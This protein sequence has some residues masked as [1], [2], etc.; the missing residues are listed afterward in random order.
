MPQL[1]T[2]PFSNGH[3]ALA[4]EQAGYDPS[5]AHQPGCYALSCH[6]PTSDLERLTRRWLR[7]SDH[8]PPYLEQCAQASQ[9]VYV[10]MSTRNVF[11]RL[12][13]HAEGEK[14]QVTFLKV[15]PPVEIHAFWPDDKPRQE[16]QSYA[17]R[18]TRELDGAYV[19]CR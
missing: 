10:G 11:D 12:I 13:D 18:L 2:T 15:F 16:E 9:I 3:V 4:L 14:R 5:D 8:A 19:H 17:D 1:E 7:F 6:K